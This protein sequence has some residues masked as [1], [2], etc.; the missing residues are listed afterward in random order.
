MLADPG[1][2]AWRRSLPVLVTDAHTMGSLAVIRSLG[3]SGYPVHACS[4]RRDALGLASNYAQVSI[5]SPEND[6]QLI[7]WLR[8]YVARNNIRAIIPSEH[9]LIVL[10]SVFQEFASLLPVSACKATVYAGL[11]KFDLFERL[12]STKELAAHLPPTLLIPDTSQ[13]PSLSE[14]EKLGTPLYIKSDSS[15]ALAGEGAA[16]YRIAS[17]SEASNL[18][19][20]IAPQYRKLVVQGHVPGQGVGVFFLLWNGE[21]GAEFMH[22]RLH[23][24][25]HTGGVSSLRESW[26]HSDIRED[27]LKKL[28]CMDWHGVAMLE[29]RWD[30]VSGEFYLMEMN[31][32]FWGSLHLALYAGVDFPRLLLDSFNGHT[33]TPPRSFVRGLRCRHTFPMEA[34]Y[35]WSRLKDRTLRLS[36]RTWTICEFFALMLDPRVYSDLLFPGDRKLYWTNLKSFLGTFWKKQI[37]SDNEHLTSPETIEALR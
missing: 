13:L 31:G 24:V 37:G 29:Y 21:V 26:W 35:V 6:Q 16:T 27:A 22:R 12:L 9:L 8:E 10:S 20:R 36:N 1:P 33:P 19:R 30:E 28:R 5:T 2:K 18:L 23:E 25:P 7:S 34:Q 11:S 14:L 3:R 15:Y 17:V 32:R 4:A